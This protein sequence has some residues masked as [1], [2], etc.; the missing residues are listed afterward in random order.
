MTA[1]R[2]GLPE[3]ELRSDS[4][5]RRTSSGYCATAPLDRWTCNAGCIHVEFEAPRPPGL[6][7]E[8]MTPTSAAALL[9]GIG[10]GLLKSATPLDWARRAA[11]PDYADRRRR[12]G[13]GLTPELEQV[14]GGDN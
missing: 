4:L 9:L 2:P 13:A 11:P 10:R 6:Q 7:S 3:C 5:A 14:E 1:G 12:S 8:V